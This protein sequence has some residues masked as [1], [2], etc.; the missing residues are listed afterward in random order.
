LVSDARGQQPTHV[1]LAPKAAQTIFAD[2]TA[3]SILGTDPHLPC[4]PKIVVDGNVPQNTGA[5]TNQS[6]AIMVY[7]PDLLLATAGAQFKVADQT[8]ATSLMLNAVV[9]GYAA[10]GYKR[11]EGVGISTGSG[12]AL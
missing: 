2:T 6:T 5:G 9:Y 11:P 3:S 4:G 7:A 10:C 1:I 12:W 8:S